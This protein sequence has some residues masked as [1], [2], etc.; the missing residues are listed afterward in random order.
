MDSVIV[1]DMACLRL[2]SNATQVCS[3]SLS[4]DTVYIALTG[5]ALNFGKDRESSL[6]IFGAVLRDAAGHVGVEGVADAERVVDWELEGF[7]EGVSAVTWTHRPWD[8]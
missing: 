3:D 7:E 8:P 1:R 4:G 5:R 6:L 2:A